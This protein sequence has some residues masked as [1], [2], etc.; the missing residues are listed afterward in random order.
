MVKWILQYI[1]DMDIGLKMEQD[2]D[3]GW[4]DMWILILQVIWVSVVLL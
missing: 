3:L 4:L 1:L 2:K